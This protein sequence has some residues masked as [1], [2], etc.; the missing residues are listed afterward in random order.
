MVTRSLYRG[1]KLKVSQEQRDYEVI[2]SIET[3]AVFFV[4]RWI[5]FDFVL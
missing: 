4:V 2:Q 1:H 3:Y 5:H